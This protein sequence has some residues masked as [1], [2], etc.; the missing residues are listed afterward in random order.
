[1]LWK[2]TSYTLNGSD[3][4]VIV[5][6]TLSH[7]TAKELNTING[8]KAQKHRNNLLLVRRYQS[9]MVTQDILFNVD[10]VSILFHVGTCGGRG[11]AIHTG[12]H[13]IS[14]TQFTL[15]A[16]LDI[17]SVSAR[18]IRELPSE[19]FVEGEQANFSTF[20]ALPSAIS[21]TSRTTISFNIHPSK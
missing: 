14:L 21:S 13:Y 10:S 20:Q 3:N 17:P 11:E 6:P 5:Y 4:I 16:I 8:R 19:S 12:I 15:L 9:S 2:C 18:C 1:M 7:H